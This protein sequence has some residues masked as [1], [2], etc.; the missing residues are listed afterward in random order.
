MKERGLGN[1]GVVIGISVIL[2][3]VVVGVNVYYKSQKNVLLGSQTTGGALCC[4]LNPD[5]TD[6][7]DCNDGVACTEDRCISEYRVSGCVGTFS[8]GCEYKPIDSKCDDRN[9]CTKDSCKL[10]DNG[11]YFCESK[12]IDCYETSGLS[13]PIEDRPLG[14]VS[15]N[16]NTGCYFRPDY[17][18]PCGGNTNNNCDDSDPNTIDTC[19]PPNEEIPYQ[20]CNHA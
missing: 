2:A 6:P 11:R 9:K 5:G 17:R 12:R 19:E 7:G 8:Y 20:H 4:H 14:C 3:L 1:L 16:R 18:C 15:C 10:S 13:I